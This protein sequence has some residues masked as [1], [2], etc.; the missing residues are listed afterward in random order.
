MISVY[1]LLDFVF[2]CRFMKFLPFIESLNNYSFNKSLILFCPS[3]FFHYLC[4]VVTKSAYNSAL[5]MHKKT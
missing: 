2:P 5:L 1:L 3:P 4:I